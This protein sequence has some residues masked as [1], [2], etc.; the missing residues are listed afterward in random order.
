M[1]SDPVRTDT[2]LLLAI[3]VV[4][5]LPINQDKTINHAR[6]SKV[7]RT[8]KITA[9]CLLPLLCCRVENIRSRKCSLL[10]PCPSTFDRPTLLADPPR[11]VRRGWYD[12]VFVEILS[13]GFMY[14]FCSLTPEMATPSSLVEESFPY[15]SDELWIAGR[16][17]LE[18]PKNLKTYNIKA[19]YSLCF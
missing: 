3:H 11:S 18:I 7:A 6:N 4:T 19:T 5:S 2:R 12:Y 15:T 17:S 8:L 9:V 13:S 14:D 16:I 1:A 10:D